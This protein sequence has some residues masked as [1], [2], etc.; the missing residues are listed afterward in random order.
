MISLLITI[1]ADRPTEDAPLNITIMGTNQGPAHSLETCAANAIIHFIKKHGKCET[2]STLV[3]DGPDGTWT[4]V[5][6]T[7]TPA[8]PDT[9][10]D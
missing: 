2:D 8:K 7:T 10:N 3:K 4:K 5:T 6:R 9:H 1:T